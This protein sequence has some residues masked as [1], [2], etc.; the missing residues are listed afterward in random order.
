MLR[1]GR[2]TGVAAASLL[3]VSGEIGLR[4][5]WPGS[6]AGGGSAGGIADEGQFGAC[7]AV[8]GPLRGSVGD[9]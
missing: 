9:E 4:A 3:T 5:C 8:G 1:I 2:K 7:A 6:S